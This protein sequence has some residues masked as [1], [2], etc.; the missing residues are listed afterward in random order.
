MCLSETDLKPSPQDGHRIMGG[1]PFHSCPHVEHRPN[2]TEQN[3]VVRII[4]IRF[5]IS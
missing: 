3:E 1:R 2:K 4:G 5:V